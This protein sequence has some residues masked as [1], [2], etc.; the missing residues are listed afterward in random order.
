M[1]ACAQT[2]KRQHSLQRSREPI[3]ES[4][5]TSVVP[6]LDPSGTSAKS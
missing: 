4:V 1:P 6:Y 3:V 2:I 5:G